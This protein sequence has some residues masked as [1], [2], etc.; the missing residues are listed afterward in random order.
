MTARCFPLL[1]IVL[2]EDEPSEGK[3]ESR[4]RAAKD[5]GG[6]GGGEAGKGTRKPG[7]HWKPEDYES[8]Q[9]AL[10]EFV[11]GSRKF[12]IDHVYSRIPGR[13]SFFA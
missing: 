9:E 5:G 2:A 1:L 10:G 12:T 8:L 13:C 4:K 7:H 6:G 11:N 3:D